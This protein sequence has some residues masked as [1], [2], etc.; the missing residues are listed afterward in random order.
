MTTDQGDG[1]EEPSD[2]ELISIVGEHLVNLFAALNAAG[3]PP[4]RSLACASRA[5]VELDQL[6]AADQG[7]EFQAAPFH[8]EALVALDM[9]TKVL[10]MMQYRS[11][12]DLTPTS[13]LDIHGQTLALL[14]EQVQQHWRSL[15]EKERTGGVNRLIV[16]GRNGHDT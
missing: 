6:A 2:V 3:V 7:R 14:R 16:P 11:P 1:V 5:L 13:L 10:P 8:A 9:L 4:G 15:I 12:A